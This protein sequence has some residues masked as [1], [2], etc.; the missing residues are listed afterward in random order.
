MRRIAVA[1]VVLTGIPAAAMAEGMP[2][3]DFANPLTISQVVW[4][5]F[6]FTVLYVALSR[7]GL[8]LVGEV[9]EARATAIA[10]DLDVAR[11]AKAD[12]DAAVAAANE[13]TRKA[14]AEA[15]AEIATA[16]GRAKEAAAA[17]A[18]E[19]NARLDAQL[20]EAEQRIGVARAAAMGA[21]RQVATETAQVVVTRL[22]GRAPRREAVDQ[23]IGAAL[24]ARGQG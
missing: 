12:S 21:L 20:A 14:Q 23:A 13:A 6:I 4:L 15:Q 9:L 16:V 3:L 5:V 18:A 19:V 10:R 2:Q 22:T 1:A 8:P 11:K 17:E 24:A 7:W